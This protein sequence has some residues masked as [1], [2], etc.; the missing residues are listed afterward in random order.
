MAPIDRLI[1]KRARATLGRPASRRR[2][3]LDIAAVDAVQ[4]AALAEGLHP[5]LRWA[6]P[7]RSVAQLARSYVARHV[8]AYGPTDG[9]INAGAHLGGTRRIVEVA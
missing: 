3:F 9:L 6:A 7:G 8:A 4:A 2:G 5:I 1:A